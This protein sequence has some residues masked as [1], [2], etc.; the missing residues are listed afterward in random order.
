MTNGISDRP[1]TITVF[2]SSKPREGSRE[3]KVAYEVGRLV[4]ESGFELCNGGYGGT[5]EAGAHGAKD[6]GGITIGVVTEFFSMN[7]NPYIDRKIVVKTLGGRLLKLLELGDAYVVLRGGTG[8]LVELATAWEYMNKHV[9]EEKPIIVV[10]NF[11]SKVVHTLK[12]ELAWEGKKSA[13]RYV[14]IVR[15]PRQCVD[16]LKKVLA[17]ES[18]R[19]G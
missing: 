12:K 15:S 11:W 1:F 17:T 19:S 10:G 18:S 6:A 5:M 4:A 16:L 3:Y 8:T 14:T 13:T 2:G 9:I 7:G